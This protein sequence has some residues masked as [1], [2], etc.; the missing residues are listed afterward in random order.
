MNIHGRLY[1]VAYGDISALESR[2]IEIKPFFHYYPGSTALT[3][4]TFG[5]NFR[6]PWCQNHHLSREKPEPEKSDYISPRRIIENALKH[7]DKGLCVS[8]QEP[9]LLFEYCLDVF[10][11]AKEQGLYCCFVSNGYQTP[12]ALQMLANAGLDGLKID[13][14]GDEG[15]YKKYCDDIDVDK[16]WRNAEEAKG[17]GMHVE[18]VNL[19]ITDVNDDDGCI[20]YIIENHLRHLGP[21]VPLH[22]TRYHPA[23]EFHNPPTKIITLEKAYQKAKK[24]GIRYP[25]IGNVPGHRYENTYCPDCGDMLIERHGHSMIENRMDEDKKCPKCGL[26]IPIFGS[27]R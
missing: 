26:K 5:C 23:Y 14:K 8:F 1:S 19:V 15:V 9:T 27:M 17:M 12:D 18:L 21:E 16:I 24:A 6:C 3:Y 25:Y 13:I 11:M 7:G 20:S 2:P 22:F 10:P 4:S